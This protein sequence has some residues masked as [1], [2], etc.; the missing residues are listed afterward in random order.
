MSAAQRRRTMK[1]FN[2]LS[3][4]F[5]TALAPSCLYSAER[6]RHVIESTLQPREIPGELK[7]FHDAVDECSAQLD[8]IAEHTEKAIGKSESEIFVTQKHIINDPKI[9]EQ[10]ETAIKNKKQNAEFAV[11]QVFKGYEDRFRAIDNIYMRERAGDIGEVRTRLLDNLRNL[12]PGFICEGQPHC[13]RGRNR[14]IVA[15]ELTPDM[16]VHMDLEN[17]KGFV[18]EHG[19]ISSHAA[20]IARS[21]GVPAV[22]G[23]H[24]LLDHVRCGD[25]ILIDGDTGTVYLNPNRKTVED[26]APRHRHDDH[27]I[28]VVRTPAGM[29]VMAN[30]G[31]LEDVRLARAVDADGIGLFRTEI[32]FLK[33]SRLLSE[34]EQYELYRRVV[35]MMDGKPVA[36]RLLDVGGDKP[37]PFLHIE[38]EANPYLG[39]RGARFLLGSPD[40]LRMQIRALARASA[41]GTLKIMFPM[42]VDSHQTAKLC[43]A[44]HEI[45]GTT[46]IEAERLEL[47]AMFEVPSALFDARGIF[48]H[49]HF[50]SVGSNDLIQYLFA[51]DRNNE[52]VSQDYNPTHPVLWEMLTQLSTVAS[53]LDK[54]LSICGEMAAVDGIPTR[55][56]DIGIRSLSVHPRLVNRVRCELNRCLMAEGA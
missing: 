45:V 13:S 42:V 52:R 37:L 17:V 39:W 24:G 35:E 43:R 23:V 33:E 53:N 20:V 4:N 36:F 40:I 54:P 21:L 48:K 50:G 49:V 51:I 18:T 32:L 15:E 2:G 10:V 30:A 44:V 47:G 41:H 56:T 29:Q 5:G 3:I 19:G 8:Q 27:E 12:R 6:H 55:L 9:V 1:V 31:M 11:H 26:L 46:D 22:S 28:E 25:R 14:V 16:V 38:E 34:D 7:R